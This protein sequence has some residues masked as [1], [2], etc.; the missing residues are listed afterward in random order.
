MAACRSSL[1][2]NSYRI[3]RTPS[4]I[5]GHRTL[6]LSCRN[7]PATR[8]VSRSPLPVS[9]RL[10][11]ISSNLY[12]SRTLY[13]HHRHRGTP[14]RH[15][16]TRNSVRWYSSTNQGGGA[17][18]GGG[19][20]SGGGGGG[21]GGGGA[22]GR[23]GFFQNFFDNLKKGVEKNQEIQESLKG[24]HEEREKLHQSYVAQQI[25]LKFAAALEKMAGVGRRGAEGWKV[26][27]DSSSKVSR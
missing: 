3:L 17:S 15:W 14:N 7:V 2:R 22:G 27:K 1:W 8:G 12:C 26:V 21:G 13:V 10:F 18:G 20:A 5:A 24:F 4:I 11:S 23:K 25:R 6:L 9:D 16:G 19:G